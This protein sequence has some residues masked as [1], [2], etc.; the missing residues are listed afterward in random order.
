MNHFKPG[1]LGTLFL[2]PA[3][4]MP[5]KSVI[6]YKAET[7]GGRG[8]TDLYIFF[9]GGGGLVKRGVVNISGWG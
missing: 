9:G 8:L 4:K 7:K 5:I 6:G 1:N 2:L 3:L